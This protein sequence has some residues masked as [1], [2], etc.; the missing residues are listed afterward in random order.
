MFSNDEYI[1]NSVHI[2]FTWKID[3][4]TTIIVLKIINRGSRCMFV[5]NKFNKFQTPSFEINIILQE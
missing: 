3:F 1:E 5:H 4:R 2:V